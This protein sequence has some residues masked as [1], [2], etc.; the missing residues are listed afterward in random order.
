MPKK[1]NIPQ[2]VEKSQ[3]ITNNKTRKRKF[4]GNKEIQT[5]KPDK[6]SGKSNERNCLQTGV[7]TTYI[8]TS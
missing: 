2:K 1:S 8:R 3:N 7:C 4:E 6:R 5:N